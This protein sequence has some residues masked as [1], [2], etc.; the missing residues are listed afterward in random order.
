MKGFER[1]TRSSILIA[2]IGPSWQ[3][4]TF[5]HCRKVQRMARH[6]LLP[7]KIRFNLNPRQEQSWLSR[8]ISLLLGRL[9]TIPK[10][11]SLWQVRIH[12]R[13]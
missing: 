11:N 5:G 6:K 8:V 3:W 2:W 4:L 9:R 1:I 13:R 7:R 10:G 12:R